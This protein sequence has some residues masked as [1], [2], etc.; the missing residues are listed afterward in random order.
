MKVSV[1]TVSFNSVNTI[2]RTLDSV[3]SQDYEDI[4]YIVVDGQS[5]D[6][7]VDIITRHR[8][9]VDVFVSEPDSG[10]FDAFNKGM[11]LANGDIIC[12]LNSD[13]AFTNDNVVSK[14]VAEFEKD[15]AD[16]LISGVIMAD[17]PKTRA[18]RVWMP[19]KYHAWML[20]IGYMPPHPGVFFKRELLEKVGSF[21][22]S[23]KISG[24]YHFL[25]RLLRAAASI[26][27]LKI[28]SVEM[29][30]RGASN[31]SVKNF[32]KKFI[33]DYRAAQTISYFGGLLIAIMKRLVKG[34]QFIISFL[35]FYRVQ[36]NKN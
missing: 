22:T 36:R 15:H 8:D 27:R 3:R 5:T 24:D 21:D 16:L 20:Y 33:E 30:T 31:N 4:E 35:G 17:S 14:V 18:V 13:D 25:I 32:L 28:Y 1:I 2:E 29:L 12:F 23:Y 6:S 34:P 9:L 11:N 26:S 10:I 19:A 7:T